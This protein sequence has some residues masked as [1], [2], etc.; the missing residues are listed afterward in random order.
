MA[1]DDGAEH[2]RRSEPK[3]LGIPLRS[4]D[5]H[6]MLR[7]CLNDTMISSH[8]TGILDGEET[9]GITNDQMSGRAGSMLATLDGSQQVG[10][11]LGALG[12]LPSGTTL[13][14]KRSK[15]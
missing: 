15:V 12:R 2:F 8:A 7:R 10:T 4:Q 6:L 1:T 5:N 13:D 9:G 11:L 14:D 3:N